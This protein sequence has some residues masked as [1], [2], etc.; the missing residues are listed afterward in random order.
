MADRYFP[1][2]V[3]YG[4]E[5][6][7][8]LCFLLPKN[9]ATIY[10]FNKEIV[11]ILSRCNGR[12]NLEEILSEVKI[13]V[14]LYKKLIRILISNKI[15]I[16]SREIYKWF[17]DH[18]LDDGDYRQVIDVDKIR[19]LKSIHRTSSQRA[20]SES[21]LHNL[22]ID[23][24][25]Q[26]SFT[27]EAMIVSDLLDLLKSMYF[28]DGNPTVPSGGGLY[29]LRF[30][31]FVLKSNVKSGI[32]RFDPATGEMRF[33]K[34]IESLDLIYFTFQDRNTIEN[35]SAIICVCADINIHPTKYA[36]RGYRYTLIEVGHACQNAYL[37][38]AE[39]KDYQVCSWG[40]MKD[41][42]LSKM[43]DLRDGIYPIVSMVIGCPD[44]KIKPY[45]PTFNKLYKLIELYYLDKKII[46]NYSCDPFYYKGH[47]LPKYCAIYEYEASIKYH[48]GYQKLKG[49]GFGV[50]YS[51]DEACIK[52]LVEALERF[53]SGN[54]RSDV[55]GSYEKLKKQ[56]I[57]PGDIIPLEN[58][59]S[60]HIKSLSGR[61]IF[62][63]STNYEWI[64]GINLRT[65]R[66]I[67]VLS[68]LVFYPI[69]E[70]LLNRRPIF[71]SSSSGVAGHFDERSATE[72]AILEL[73][74]R[75]AFSVM[76][77]SKKEI[78]AFPTNIL[79]QHI[80]ERVKF[81]EKNGRKILFLDLTLDSVP[82]VLCIISGVS[83]P[84]T[85]I[86]VKAHYDLSVAIEKSFE[87]AEYGM[88]AWLEKKAESIKAK[89]V[90]S[91]HDHAAFYALRQDK[92]I[93]TWLLRSKQIS[94]SSLNR[95]LTNKVTFSAIIKKFNLVKIVVHEPISRDDVWIVRVISSDLMPINFGYGTEYYGHKRISM[96]GL[97]W[98]REYPSKPHF[99][100]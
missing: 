26:R 64:Y 28:M 66:K 77:Y 46:S 16:D 42:L 49:R 74:E 82:V 24:K 98:N 50:A 13:D 91:P 45:I 22:L 33:F 53:Y 40:A 92:D 85:V 17:H 5:K 37:W 62:S 76:W 7:D 48:R 54:F 2:V 87:E 11:K 52:A 55:I 59:I 6:G 97:K 94:S 27:G 99:F 23:R 67:L 71:R 39:K 44:K 86:G 78:F 8:A 32:Y 57:Y 4:Y 43:L 73:I 29:P 51:K 21:E 63:P 25:S 84:H 68:D 95:L 3:A 41:Q 30:F 31:I 79:S 88:L 89:D 60:G 65:K 15:V 10:G 34:K 35:V 58:P 83:Y 36:N 14:L 19:S 20:N 1:L 38:A 96:L 47:L 18:T 70:G 100:P 80:Y 9:T 75:D 61:A 81:W 90:V 93:Q 72:N 56:A 12:K 69:K